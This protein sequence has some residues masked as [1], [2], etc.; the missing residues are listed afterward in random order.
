MQKVNPF[1][2]FDDNAEEAVNF[3]VST[4]K[5]SKI[6]TTTRYSEASSKA[7]GRPKDSVMTVAFELFGQSFT[8]IN[9]GPYLKLILPFH[10]L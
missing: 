2:W 5:D 6:K 9:G 4:F 3:Y 8:A 1:L 7:A 10:S